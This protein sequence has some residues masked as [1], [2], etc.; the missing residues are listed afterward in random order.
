VAVLFE[1]CSRTYSL[2]EIAAVG[3]SGNIRKERAK[4]VIEK[5]ASQEAIGVMNLKKVIGGCSWF[6]RVWAHP[7]SANYNEWF[8]VSHSR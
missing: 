1:D 7:E 2:D 5:G 3:F 4:K 6:E 8:A